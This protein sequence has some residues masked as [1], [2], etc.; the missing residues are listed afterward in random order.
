[1]EMRN[2]MLIHKAWLETRWRF[3]AGLALLMAI[4]VYTVLRAPAIIRD[5]EQFRHEHILYAQYIWILLYKGFLQ[6]I[7]ILSAVMLGIGGVWREKA[8]G[9]AGFTLSL[10]VSR[11]QLVLVRAAVGAIEVITL[12]VVPSLLVW[13]I[14]VLTGHPYPLGD[15]ISH[16][17]L[18][19][20]GGLIFYGLSVLLSHLMQG[21]LS[22]PT[23][24]LGSCLVLY[25]A[26][27]L[28]ELETYN[29]FDLM[30]GKHYLDPNTF[31]LVGAW[32][33]LPLGL[34]F[35][36]AMGMVFISARI[37]EARDF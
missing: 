10:P 4:S 13:A 28:L 18:M 25:L 7:W 15:A 22:V 12:A 16:A 32:P 23:L 6:T 17:V 3:L 29:P 20:G 30:S 19:V 14:S 37:A 11:Q 21:E 35:V 5:R 36:L 24:A 2:A 31:L 8:S 34:F 1:M 27:Q 26:F 9:V 33:W